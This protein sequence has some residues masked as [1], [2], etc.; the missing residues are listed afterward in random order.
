MRFVGEDG[1]KM[2]RLLWRVCG[3]V[4]ARQL[5]GREVDRRVGGEGRE[6]RVRVGMLLRVVVRPLLCGWCA[7]RRGGVGCINGLVGVAD[8]KIVDG[9]ATEASNQSSTE[10]SACACETAQA[11]ASSF[12]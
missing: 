6:R 10:R 1:K 2:L 5:E 12:T 4:W 9:D 7:T 8:R 3:V 11:P